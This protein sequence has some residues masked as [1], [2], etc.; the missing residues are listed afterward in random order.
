[1]MIVEHYRYSASKH[2]DH[3][4]QL[5]VSVTIHIRVKTVH[6]HVHINK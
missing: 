2:A 5:H 4:L 3:I 1:M 6:V